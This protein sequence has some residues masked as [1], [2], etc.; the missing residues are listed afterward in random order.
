MTRKNVSGSLA[1]LV[2]NGGTFN[3]PY[4]AGSARGDYVN[5]YQHQILVGQNAYNAPNR[6]GIVL[7]AANVTVTNRSGGAWAQGT[8]YVL[9]LDIGGEGNGILSSSG[10]VV[11][12]A[13]D[14]PTVYYNLGSPLALNASGIRVA[15]AV[16]AAGNL[17]GLLLG[18]LDVP[19]NV[20]IQCAGADA[21]RVFTVTGT[22]V[23]GNRV[24]ENIAGSAAGTT[25]G[26]KAFASI[27][28]ISVDA[29]T[30]GN[31]NV[32]WG[33]VLGLPGFVLSAVHVQKEMVDLAVAGA[34]TF[35]FG[36]QAPATATTGD[37]RGTYVPAAAPDGAKSYGIL[38]CS[39]DPGYI[40]ADQFAG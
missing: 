40:G 21:A 24:V 25:A 13:V 37:T 39:P 23:I 8:D 28:S 22:D 38:V 9:S 11:P 12:R 27:T 29:A 7:G 31:V 19:R 17:G 3:S 10:K 34:G 15:A 30:A 20:T 33:N 36:D 26:K 6:V 4:P 14:W 16:A 32:G 18:Q 5:G 2:A 1:A 35:V